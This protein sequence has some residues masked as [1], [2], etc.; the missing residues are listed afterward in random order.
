MTAGRLKSNIEYRESKFETG[1]NCQGSKFETGYRRAKAFR[2]FEI[3]I[4]ELFR[5]SVLGLRVSRR[6]TGSALILTVVLTSLLALIGVL[7]IMAAR[8]DKMGTTAT[9]DSRELDFAVD[10]VVAQICETLADDVPGVS[11]NQERYDYPD[12]NNLWLADLEPVQVSTGSYAWRQVSNLTGVDTT[13][14][15]DVAISSVGE[16]DLIVDVNALAS[17]A[18]ADGDGVSDARWYRIP[19][20][21]SGRGKP[22]YAAVRIID[23]GGLLNVNAAH[24]FN[25]SFNKILATQRAW[26]DGSRLSQINATALAGN[27]DDVTSAQANATALLRARG[28]TDDVNGLADYDNRVVWGYL[29]PN[30]SNPYPYTPFDLS[31]ELEL[32]YR[33]LLNRESVDT[34]AEKWGLFRGNTLSTPV[35][36]GGAEL[37]AWFRRATNFPGTSINGLDPNYAYRHVATTYNMDRLLAPQPIQVP[38]RP[39]PWKQVNVNVE[40][41]AA[42]A[43]AVALALGEKNPNVAAVSAAAA[44][45]TANLVDY[46]DDDDDEVTAIPDNPAAPT[47]WYFGFERPCIY[48]SEIA[49]R[50]VPDPEDPNVIHRSYAI[51]LYK[52]YFEDNSPKTSDWQLV[53]TSSSGRQEVERII[54]SGTRR[55]HVMLKEDSVADLFD[56]NDF[57]DPNAATDTTPYDRSLYTDPL[58]QNMQSSFDEGD[59]ISLERWVIPP[60]PAQSQTWVSVD[61]VTVPS[62]WMAMDPNFSARSIQRDISPHKCIRRLWSAAAGAPGLGG[63]ANAYVAA[64]NPSRIIQVHPANRPLRNIGELGMVFA[65]S[66]YD[67]NVVRDTTAGQ[68]LFDLT[69]PD[70]A[71]VFNYLTVIDPTLRGWD[72]NEAR[73]MGRINVNT[74]P[75]LVLGQLPWMR[76]EDTVAYGKAKAIVDHRNANGPFTSPADLMRVNALWTLASD[77][78]Q[79]WYDDTP[80]GPDLDLVPD[81]A[82][83][84]LEERD[85]LFRRVSDLV[86]VRSDVF[87]AYILVRID[88]DGPQRRMMAILDRSDVTAEGGRVR[89]GALHLVPDP[90]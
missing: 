61:S 67:D 53:I 73:V 78:K 38:G 76:Y 5:I 63:P 3:R 36:T 26:V 43:E 40:P 58:A 48:I 18:D 50:F 28:I 25:D 83:D 33:F 89:V 12:A 39:N 51:E 54:W 27:A 84:D 32:R 14:T 1:S 17:D 82:L 70:Y 20:L 59:T 55:F 30:S 80:R 68:V 75:W 16:H 56:D 19:G 45:I 77:G 41:A 46:M 79:N 90:R 4:S 35:D 65:R 57:S 21:M 2:S 42:I 34:L 9:A 72:A 31:D 15:K 87:T 23:N 24:W 44:Q 22:I 11:P 7:F 88:R 10:T 60:A 8:L 37:D 66:A 29:R 47:V 81:G 86:T 64:E 6:A 71:R 13:D 85:L 49:C 52:P 69:N 62:G 74:A